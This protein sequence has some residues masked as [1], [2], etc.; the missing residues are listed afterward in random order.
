M[1]IGMIK[2]RGKINVLSAMLL[3]VVVV[4]CGNTALANAPDWAL[5]PPADTSNY[6]YGVGS[7]TNKSQAP[8]AAL[9]E[10]AS[11]WS[12]SIEVEDISQF[13]LKDGQT[14]DSYVSNI[15]SQVKNTEFSHYKVMKT[16]KV[17]HT[18]WVLVQVDR[19]KMISELKFKIDQVKKDVNRGIAA[20]KTVSELER[21]EIATELRPKLVKLRATVGTL[22]IIDSGYNAA[23]DLDQISQQLIDLKA[24]QKIVVSIQN[25]NDS[26]VFARDLKSALTEKKVRIGSSSQSN[27]VISISSD[28]E[29]SHHMGVHWAKMS[30]DIQAKDRAGKILAS[31]I[32]QVTGASPTS[33]QAALQNANKKLTKKL[34]EEGLLESIGL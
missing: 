7:S 17:K 27:T 4:L 24:A 30:V 20:L 10:I 31:N 11:R 32:H 25:D 29:Y 15:K 22:R 23:K 8:K 34:E 3:G 21:N 12:V 19:P 16:D 18:Y 33:K 14:R 6:Y 9:A 1:N 26:K 28:L 2:G 5:K 13:E